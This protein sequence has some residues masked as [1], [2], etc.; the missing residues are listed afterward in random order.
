MKKGDK[1]IQGRKEGRKERKKRWG[2]RE[3]IPGGLPAK[4]P[5]LSLLWCRFHPWPRNFCLLQAWLG[6]GKKKRKG[7]DRNR[8]YDNILLLGP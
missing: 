1:N 2:R 8:A 4:D 3:G 5:A 7:Q 6:G